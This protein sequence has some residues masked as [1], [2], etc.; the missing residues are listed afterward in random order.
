MWSRYTWA[1]VVTLAELTGHLSD[2]AA[3]GAER[4]VGSFAAGNWRRQTE[5]LA[6]AR[7]VLD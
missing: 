7:A 5:L 6:E 4:V 2:H 3:A 1:L